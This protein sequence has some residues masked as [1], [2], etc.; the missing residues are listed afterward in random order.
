MKFSA[1]NILLLATIL[2]YRDQQIERLKSIAVERGW[3][4]ASVFTDGPTTVRKG[5][6]R[7]AREV[8]LLDAIRS[9]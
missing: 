9:G 3:T 7:R 8:A 6:D 5:L 1:P 4:V 2:R